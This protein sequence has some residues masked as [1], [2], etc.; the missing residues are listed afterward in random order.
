MTG[1]GQSSA[2]ADRLLAPD[3]D[4]FDTVAPWHDAD[5]DLR[6]LAARAATRP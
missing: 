1:T 2:I 3:L 4:G 6:G 5:G